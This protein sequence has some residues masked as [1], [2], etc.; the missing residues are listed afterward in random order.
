MDRE[1]FGELV[2]AAMADIPESLADRLV[3]ESTD[4]PTVPELVEL[5]A[6]FSAAL[7]ESGEEAGPTVA[8]VATVARSSAS[9]GS[10]S[11]TSHGAL[12][13]VSVPKL[14]P[15]ISSALAI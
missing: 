14:P 8:A 10:P 6:K 9:P 12:S 15:I 7:D 13:K 3:R 2:V 1:R 5:V 4:Q 11:S